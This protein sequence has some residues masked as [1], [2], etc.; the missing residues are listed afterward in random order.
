MARRLVLVAVSLSALA[1]LAAGC[2][3]GGDGSKDTTAW[4]GDLCSA[5]TTW[6]DS[7]ADSV[8]SI[9]AVGLTRAALQ[10]VGRRREGLDR[11]VRR[12][13]HRASASRTRRREPRPQDTVDELAA[14]LED[15]VDDIETARHQVLDD[16]RARS[17]P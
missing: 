1:L 7:M 3:G 9:R 14:D 17:R 8:R 11:R 5:I 10:S 15:G 2:G 4:A 6:Q 16:G 12:R 13:A